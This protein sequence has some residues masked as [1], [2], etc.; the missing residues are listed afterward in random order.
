MAISLGRARGGMV[1]NVRPDIRRTQVAGKVEELMLSQQEV[2]A[3]AREMMLGQQRLEATL[4]TLL[5]N[6]D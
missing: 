3:K 5:S 1:L 4:Q 2:T 6:L